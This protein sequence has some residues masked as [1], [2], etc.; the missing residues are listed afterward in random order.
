MHVPEY[1]LK[2]SRPLAHHSAAFPIVLVGNQ[3]A[4]YGR[5]AT[6][7]AVFV[8]RERIVRLCARH[9]WTGNLQQR[10]E[11]KLPARDESVR[12]QRGD[13]LLPAAD[14]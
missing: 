6:V 8:F 1:S 2:L 11:Q 4:D 5:G 7:S 14:A 12:L 13:L 3:I 10:H 9:R